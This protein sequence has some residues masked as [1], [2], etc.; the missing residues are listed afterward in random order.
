MT[1][2]NGVCG[3]DETCETC[4]KDC[5][6]CAPCVHSPCVTGAPLKKDCSPCVAKICQQDPFCCTQN[7]D[8][9]CAEQAASNGCGCGG[10]GG[11]GGS[12]GVAGAGGAGQGGATGGTA[13][14]AGAGA[15]SGAGGNTQQQ[16]LVCLVGNCG[17]QLSAC[18]NQALCQ[19]CLNNFTVTCLG[20]PQWQAL[21][22]CTCSECGP[23]CPEACGNAPTPTPGVP[24]A[25]A[26]PG[27]SHDVCE[28]GEPLEATCSPCVEEVCQ[29]D[30]FCCESAWDE[31][32]VGQHQAVCGGDPCPAPQP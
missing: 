6:S 7:W 16:C 26:T 5:G 24:G 10:A 3:L 11:S 1:C 23:T 22:T 21:F 29:Q 18:V 4:P 27:C 17:P 25:F 32:C 8:D 20:N 31:S 30:P 12:G 9:V 13:G 2:G 28:I 19:Q 14:S 15:T